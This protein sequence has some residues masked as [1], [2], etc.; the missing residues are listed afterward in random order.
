M[1]L[2]S[3][4][5]QGAQQIAR[6]IALLRAITRGSSSGRRLQDLASSVQLA[7]PTA[8]RILKALMREGL[9]LQEPRTKLYRLGPL[10]FEFGLVRNPL[11]GAIE[12]CRPLIREL[13]HE[14]GD[15]AFLCMRSGA[16]L[17]CMDRAE[18]DFPI[19]ASM[20]DM[21]ERA[22]L[23]LGALG[24]SLLSM[25]S[26]S[27]ADEMITSLRAD[28][29]QFAEISVETIRERMERHRKDGYVFIEHQP[30]RHV[31][32]IASGVAIGVHGQSFG[33]ATV[34]IESRFNRNHLKLTIGALRR[35]ADA[36]AVALKAAL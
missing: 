6:A 4:V 30:M 21:G 35:C 8:H 7:P 36:V 1:P 16:D 14:T 31:H 20:L 17:I 15:T 23:G 33:V 19:R 11:A 28:F 9:V 24:V 10:A 3:P 32:S 27:E 22:P 25:L 2:A 12:A 26:D 34:A 13:A 18:G 5:T 29:P